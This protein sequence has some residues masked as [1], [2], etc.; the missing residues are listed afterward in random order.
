MF[1]IGNSLREA[2][3]RQGLDYPQVELATKI[4]A[5]Y[6]R[7][8]EEEQFDVLPAQPYVKGFLRTYAD[9]LGLDGQL[10][11]DEYD[12][13][14]V[15]DGLD[16]AP[17]RRVAPRAR[18][19]RG[20]E[21]KVVLLALAG[22]A[23]LA[24]LVIVGVEVRRRRLVRLDAGRRAAAVCADGAPRAGLLRPGYVCRGAP[25]LGDRRGAV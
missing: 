13:R 12:S 10:Y 6:I 16:E 8:L 23:A 24:A 15:V 3:V 4:R 14:F 1:E 19:E 25:G 7:A 20:I 18:R 17:L 22:I 5:K 9:F 11:V 2:R 21:R